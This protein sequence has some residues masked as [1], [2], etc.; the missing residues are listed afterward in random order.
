MVIPVGHVWK[1]RENLAFICSSTSNLK[2]FI[3]LR[4]YHLGLLVG[5]IHDLWVDRK[6][7]ILFFVC[8]N[9]GLI[10]SRLQ[11]LVVR[12]A[13]RVGSRG[14]IWPSYAHFFL[15][16][17]H[18]KSYSKIK[19]IILTHYNNFNYFYKHLPQKKNK[20]DGFPC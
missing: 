15:L 5:R 12:S 3:S 9:E 1:K 17:W 18:S 8:L 13:G 20:K 4:L 2:P 14:R 10:T 7:F 11:C 16:S 6:P 19:K